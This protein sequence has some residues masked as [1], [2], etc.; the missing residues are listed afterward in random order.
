MMSYK[1]LLNNTD[2]KIYNSE[3]CV[4]LTGKLTDWFICEIGAKQGDSLYPTLF[5]VFSNDLVKE[6]NDQDMAINIADNK[7]PILVYADDIAIV[8][9]NEEDHQH[10]LNKL[11]CWCNKWKV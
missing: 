1:L 5:T 6:V 4:R 7:L 3:S 10:L 8:A 2:V 9:N 11:Y